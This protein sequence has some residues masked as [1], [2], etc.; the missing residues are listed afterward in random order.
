[1]LVAAMTGMAF[2]KWLMVLALVQLGENNPPV[3]KGEKAYCT[4]FF[5]FASCLISFAFLH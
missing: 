3:Q 5:P 1:M 2:V 4:N